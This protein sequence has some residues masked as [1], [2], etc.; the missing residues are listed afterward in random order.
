MI[1]KSSK[2]V[3]MNSKFTTPGASS[4]LAG[5]LAVIL[6]NPKEILFYLDVLLGFFDLAQITTADITVILII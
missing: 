1:L 6:S 5:G 3:I 2:T 4:G